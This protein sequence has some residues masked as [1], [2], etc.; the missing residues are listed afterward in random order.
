MLDPIINDIPKIKDWC[1]KNKKI[2]VT[3]A[4]VLALV[5]GSGLVL[6]EMFEG[7][8]D[9]YR[10]EQYQQLT[11]QERNNGGK[12]GGDD[13]GDD[14][15]TLNPQLALTNLLIVASVGAIVVS[16]VFVYISLSKKKIKPLPVLY[17]PINNNDKEVE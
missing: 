14:T 5:I 2:T 10:Y 12:F 11:D 15:A 6:G 8:H 16:G 13:G 9:D 17:N 3:I 1:L 4:V 7:D